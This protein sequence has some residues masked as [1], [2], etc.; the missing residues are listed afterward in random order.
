M[1]N[2]MKRRV[3]FLPLFPT[4]VVVTKE[5]NGISSSLLGFIHNKFEGEFFVFGVI[6]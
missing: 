6:A 5:S 4:Q 3:A 1:A 2:E